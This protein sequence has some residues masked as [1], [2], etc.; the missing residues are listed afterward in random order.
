MACAEAD[1][2]S[3]RWSEAWVAY[4]AV[5]ADPQT[6]AD[7]VVDAAIG[8]ARAALQTQRP[9]DA[10]EVLRAGLELTEDPGHRLPLLSMRIQALR[11]L[12]RSEEIL[13]AEVERDSLAEQ[14]PEIAWSAFLESAG[15]ARSQGDPT[16]AV[17]LLGKALRLQLSTIQRA[18]VLVELGAAHVDEADFESAA[19]RFTQAISLGSSD[20]LITFHAGMGHAELHPH[21]WFGPER[22]FAVFFSTP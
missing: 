15:Q 20:P 17:E 22:A 13:K 3:G 16:A 21:A 18:R 12:G 10:D 2:R 14:A 19:S 5:L 11:P 8:A 1:E 4:S 9:A 6:P 7:V